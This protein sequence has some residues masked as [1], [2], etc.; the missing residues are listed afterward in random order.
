MTEYNDDDILIPNEYDE[1]FFDD[2]RI[3]IIKTEEE[4][5]VKETLTSEDWIDLHFKSLNYLYTEL[6][7]FPLCQ[8]ASFP[9]FCEY[10]LSVSG[11]KN[12]DIQAWLLYAPQFEF[13]FKNNRRPKLKEFA[14]HHIH[15]LLNMYMFIQN[16]SNF[17]LGP[18]KLF[19]SFVYRYSDCNLN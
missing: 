9:D 4:N 2:D 14:S 1:V 17:S 15:D 19:I 3:Y 8:R 10:I 6:C 5:F 18:V 13:K 11:Y 16:N 12:S 7:N